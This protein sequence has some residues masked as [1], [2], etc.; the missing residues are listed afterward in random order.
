MVTRLRL[1]HLNHIKAAC[2]YKCAAHTHTH[3]YVQMFVGCKFREFRE[4]VQFHENPHQR[5]NIRTSSE[6]LYVYANYMPVL[7]FEMEQRMYIAD[8]ESRRNFGC[9]RSLH[10]CYDLEIETQLF[11]GQLIICT[12]ANGLLSSVQFWLGYFLSSATLWTLHG[13]SLSNK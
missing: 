3:R 9:S 5:Q 11:T 6:H 2:E 7:S 1:C 12:F 10:C 8:N 4:W 13:S